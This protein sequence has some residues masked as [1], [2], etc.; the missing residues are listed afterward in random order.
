M[1]LISSNEYRKIYIDNIVTSKLNDQFFDLDMEELT[2]DH[3]RRLAWG[4]EFQMDVA[5]FQ[6]ELTYKRRVRFLCWALSTETEEWQ[7]TK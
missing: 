5:E 6:T 2:E 3:I 7:A 4:V 1:L